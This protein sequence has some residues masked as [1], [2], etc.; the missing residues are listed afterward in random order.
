MGVGHPNASLAELRGYR[1]FDASLITVEVYYSRTCQT[2]WAV[3]QNSGQ[4]VAS[5]AQ[6]EV[7]VGWWVPGGTLWYECPKPGKALTTAM[8]NDHDPHGGVTAS[9]NVLVSEGAGSRQR[10]AFFEFDD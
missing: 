6:C 2:L 9:A 3:V 10:W 1:G 5:E 7:N 8:V 4:P